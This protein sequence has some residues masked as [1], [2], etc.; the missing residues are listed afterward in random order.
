MALSLIQSIPDWAVAPSSPAVASFTFGASV[1]P[2][3]TLIV[4]SIMDAS[5]NRFFSISD[6]VQGSTGW[7][8]QLFTDGS[9]SYR[10]S[11]IWTNAN[12]PGGSVSV[13]V[14]NSGSGVF[15]CFGMEWNGFGTEVTLEA[16]DFIL[17][18]PSSFGHSASVAG[19]SSPVECLAILGCETQSNSI[20]TLDSGYSNPMVSQ[21]YTRY[22]AGYQ[23]FPSGVSGE[24]GSWTT[25]IARPGMS[26]L[27][28]LSGN[29]GG[30]SAIGQPLMRRWGGVPGMGTPKGFGR[31]W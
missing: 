23:I 26:I 18:S 5:N 28:L 17:E 24:H 25:S 9:I 21:N 14:V 12:H 2:G 3:S 13:T 8:A 6:S 1:T 31:S 27:G 19:L 4:M 11:Y 20:I 30:G 15:K 10:Q 29:A 22:A 16:G 7:V